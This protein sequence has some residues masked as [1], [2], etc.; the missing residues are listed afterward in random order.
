M[1]QQ[2]RKINLYDKTLSQ[3][4]AALSS[5]SLVVIMAAINLNIISLRQMMRS[6][7]CFH[8][9]RSFSRSQARIPLS[10]PGTSRIR[11]P[12]EA[13][14]STGV[15]TTWSSKLNSSLRAKAKM[16]ER[17]EKSLKKMWKWKR[18]LKEMIPLLIKLW[19][20]SLKPYKPLFKEWW[21]SS[22]EW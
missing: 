18:N 4:A 5:V 15:F 9:T 1:G 22:S 7:Y 19:P 16:S 10:F 8:K 2:E 14:V 21:V 13:L 20:K 12:R 3:F 11:P 17:K 6:L